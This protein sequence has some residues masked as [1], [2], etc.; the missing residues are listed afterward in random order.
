MAAEPGKHDD[1]GNVSIRLVAGNLGPQMDQ[2]RSVWKSFMPDEPMNFTFYDEQFDAMY[3]KDDQLS[4]A[5]GIVSVIALILTFMGILGQV[6]QISLN[7][8]KEIGVRKVNG[9]T[10]AN[11][12]TYMN[13]EFIIWVSVALV[14]ATPLAWYLISRWL[15]NFAYKTTIGWPIYAASGFIMLATVVIT[16]TLQSWKAATRN[17]VEALRYE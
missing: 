16:V 8:T 3:R 13:R 6:F 12:L 17:P 7:R 1:L 5:I 10:V 14:I 4:K 15:E 9:A 2:L 11:I